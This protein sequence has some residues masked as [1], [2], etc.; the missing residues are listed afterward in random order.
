MVM[1]FSISRAHYRAKGAPCDGAV[2]ED[3]EWFVAF[4][5]LE[6]F[7]AWV[8]AL[9]DSIIFDGKHITIYDDYVE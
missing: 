7:T 9:S 8:I 5:T 1:K 2:L 4:D 6:Q 3:D